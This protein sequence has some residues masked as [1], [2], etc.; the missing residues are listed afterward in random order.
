MLEA[1]IRAKTRRTALKLAFLIVLNPQFKNIF[2]IYD[3][4]Q[5]SHIYKSKS[6][7]GK[8]FFDFFQQIALINF[9]S[10][11][12][13]G[14]PFEIEFQTHFMKKITI[15]YLFSLRMA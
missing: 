12:I 14:K 11:Y 5:G 1:P 4:I 9:R 8:D 3:Q 13:P 15:N 7:N 2:Q 6:L 10:L